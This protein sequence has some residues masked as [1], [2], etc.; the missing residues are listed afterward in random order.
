MEDL[1]TRVLKTLTESPEACAADGP[2]ALEDAS[3]ERN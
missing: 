2:R 3:E 1:S